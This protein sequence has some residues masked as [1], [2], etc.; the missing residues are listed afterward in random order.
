MDKTQDV[1]QTLL[2][3]EVLLADGLQGDIQR[4]KLADWLG[5][6]LAQ[7]AALAL[8]YL[9][10]LGT[11]G[12]VSLPSMLTKQAIIAFFKSNGSLYAIRASRGIFSRLFRTREHTAHS[13]CRTALCYAVQGKYEKAEVWLL[14]AE[15]RVGD[16]ARPNYV[17]GL[18]L[19]AQGRLDEAAKKLFQSLQ[20]RAKKET[21]ERIAEASQVL[22]ELRGHRALSGEGA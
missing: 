14:S 19:G 20:G 17:R 10:R 22:T 13:Y 11:R 12:I 9:I 7:P 21:K 2:L 5:E 8:K 15:E 6:Q 16:L 1:F 4:A 18:M 3:R